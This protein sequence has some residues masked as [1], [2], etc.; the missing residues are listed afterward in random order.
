MRLTAAVVTRAFRHTVAP[1]PIR[2][3]TRAADGSG[4]EV[5]IPTAPAVH[6][7]IHPRNDPGRQAAAI[8]YLEDHLS[9]LYGVALAIR[10]VTLLRGGQSVRVTIGPAQPE[11]GRRP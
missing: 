6:T 3:R 5:D 1:R 10:S 11:P 2:L 8:R 9:R 4:Y 7:G